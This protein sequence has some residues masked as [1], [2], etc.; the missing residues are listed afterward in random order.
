LAT[1]NNGPAF[2]A[3]FAESVSHVAP[4]EDAAIVA[5][6]VVAVVVIDVIAVVVVAV[7]V[8]ALVAVIVVAIADAV[9]EFPIVVILVVL[10]RAAPS[11]T[12]LFPPT[13]PLPSSSFPSQQHHP[14]P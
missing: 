9:I 3:H 12:S 2:F 10:L 14:S 7:I 13:A 5:V 4:P 1:N 8:V 6:V 11:L